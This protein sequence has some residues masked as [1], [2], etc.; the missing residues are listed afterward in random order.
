MAIQTTIRTTAALLVL[1]STGAQA[2]APSHG[3][4]SKA[5]ASASSS[6]QLYGK[7]SKE[8]LVEMTKEY[9]ASSTPDK[10]ADDYVF[11]G[12]VIGPLVKKEFH[13]N[14]AEDYGAE[15]KSNNVYDAFPDY[16]LNAFGF[17]A[18]DPIDE[19]RV[20]YFVRPRGTF[21]EHYDHPIKGRIE[22]TGA[23]L[24]A[25]PE[26]RSVT[27]N[28]DGKIQF[29]TVGY[30]TDRFTGDTTGGKGAVFAHFHVM[31]EDLDG[32]PGSLSMRF[33][34]WLGN[35]LPDVPNSFSK[36]EEIPSWWTD[37]RMGA[38]K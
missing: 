37:K 36:P 32:N 34:Q 16:E 31:G 26:A 1:L 3:S 33:R 17:T 29:E 22:P 20:W 5:A 27:W 7:F 21:T 10:L 25:P 15:E 8:E 4:M 23:P 13:K 2:F 11:R 6:S 24:I 18:D 14:T 38:E 19:N 12:P 9:L 35:M 28:D 30:V